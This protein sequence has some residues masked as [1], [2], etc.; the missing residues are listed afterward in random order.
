MTLPSMHNMLSVNKTLGYLFII[1][2][3]GG[4]FT[5]LIVQKA[6]SSTFEIDQHLTEISAPVQKNPKI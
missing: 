5:I 1:A 2:I 3:V 6:Y 4:F